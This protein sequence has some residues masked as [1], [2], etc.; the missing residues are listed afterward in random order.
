M[1]KSIVKKNVLAAVSV[2][3]LLLTGCQADVE[4]NRAETEALKEQIAQLEQQ[5]A[6]LQQQQSAAGN[7]GAANVNAPVTD[8]SSAQGQADSE[9]GGVQ[10]GAVSEQSQN[11]TGVGD[12][13]QSQNDTGVGNNQQSQND[14]VAGNNQQSQNNTGVTS[15]QQSQNN[16]SIGNS[17]QSNDNAGSDAQVPYDRNSGYSHS[18]GHDDG[19]GHN[20]S[21]YTGGGSASNQQ[22]VSVDG[23]TTYTMDELSTMVDTFVTKATAA[24]PSGQAA[25][26]MEQFFALKQEEKQ[27]DDALDS[28]EDE[29]EYLYKTGSLTREVYKQEERKLELLEDQLDDIEDQLEY[30]F[31]IKD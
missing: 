12:S 25:Q 8:E 2:A 7:D 5:I 11:G 24:A 22:G 1:K 29:L 9:S 19:Y 18:P 3:V 23:L 4:S 28:H 6:D 10:T 27:I 13:G 21:H 14:T 20:Q 17:Q 30:V 16:T 26:D 15:S 31:G